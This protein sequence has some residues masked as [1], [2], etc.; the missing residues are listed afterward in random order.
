VRASTGAEKI[1]IPS[2]SF[3]ITDFIPL[4][5]HT[6]RGEG[7][8]GIR[9][10][11]YPGAIQTHSDAEIGETVEKR[12]VDSVVEGLTGK[13]V[14][15]RVDLTGHD[16]TAIVFEGTFEEVN[17][18][19]YRRGWTDGL[20]IVPPTL[21][22]VKEFLKYTDR[23]AD[24]E[25]AVL[26]LSYLRATPWNIAVNA[27]MA[28][29]RPEYMPVLVAAVAAIADPE[30]RLKD[31][32]NTC[33]CRPFFLV[34]GPITK[35][36]AIYSGTGLMSPG[37]KRL[38]TVTTAANPNSTIGRALHLI[39]QNI[40]GFRPSESEMAVFGHAQS[41]VIAEN[42]EETPW[43]PYHVEQGFERG[44]STVTAMA[45][46]GTIGPESES[47]GERAFL[48]LKSIGM[49]LRNGMHP[50]AYRFG[51][52]V[53]ICVLMV[54]P[55]AKVIATEGY[56]KRSA[57]EQIFEESRMS[58][59]QINERLQG[60]MDTVH[61]YVEGGNAPKSLDLE[62]DRLIPAVLRPDLIHIVVCGS[63]HRNRTLILYSFYVHP[64]TKEIKIPANWGKS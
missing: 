40:A 46:M 26:P 10:A 31:I 4:A 43:E 3:V 38:G 8:P 64:V 41:F 29:C 58:V 42:E 55:I 52:R 35:D 1:G 5:N 63:R 24:E 61:S 18:F 39:V 28:G 21:P 34:N 17:E 44:T 62:S 2:V 16:P 57:A 59:R 22:K 33:G 11:E 9:I 45:W 51:D 30:F 50:I 53:M 27:V 25:I 6:A 54:P 32:G 23:G 47:K 19:F 14:E 56:S 15:N 13:L 48:H 36:L 20:P 12:I 7:M 60:E 37:A 49:E